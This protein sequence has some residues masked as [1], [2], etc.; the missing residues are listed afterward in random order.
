ME[1]VLRNYDSNQSAYEKH[2]QMTL[3]E[4]LDGEGLSAEKINSSANGGDALRQSTAASQL[5]P[6]MVVIKNIINDRGKQIPKKNKNNLASS[7]IRDEARQQRNQERESPCFEKQEKPFQ[8][9]PT[10]T[11]TLP[12]N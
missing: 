12:K 11:P 2:N 10:K 8:T 9:K 5:N 4:E 6:P 7:F 1:P 3:V